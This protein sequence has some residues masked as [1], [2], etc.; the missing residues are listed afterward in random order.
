ML[1]YTPLGMPWRWKHAAQLSCCCASHRQPRCPR[2]ED[3]DSDPALRGFEPLDHDANVRATTHTTR[4]PASAQAHSAWETWKKSG[5]PLHQPPV[6]PHSQGASSSMVEPL[7]NLMSLR[8][9]RICSRERT[10]SGAAVTA[11]PSKHV[12]SAPQRRIGTSSTHCY[13]TARALSG[14]SPT[15][16]RPHSEGAS[17]T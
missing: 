7:A 9:L 10:R 8:P 3:Q 2:S 13:E 11:P 1:S 16:R 6:D 4:R 12:H 15:P 17:P 14:A 5:M